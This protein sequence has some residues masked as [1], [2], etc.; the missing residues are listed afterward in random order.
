MTKT[1]APHARATLCL[2]IPH[3]A[4]RTALEGHMSALDG[5]VAVVTGGS[6]GIGRATAL[7]LAAEGADIAV[8]GRNQ[9]A[10]DEVASQVR[11]MGRR[12]LPSAVDVREETQGRAP[13]KLV[14]A[15]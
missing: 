11:A 5:K 6:S 15:K 10:L 2:P 1:Q 8:V 9:S 3:Y 13:R 12:A 7:A 14:Q 4:R